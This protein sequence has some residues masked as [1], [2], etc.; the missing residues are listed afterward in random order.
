MSVKIKLSYNTD[1]ELA[2]VI[3]LLSPALKSYKMQPPKGRYNRAYM[4]LKPGF[5]VRSGNE[6]GK[7]SP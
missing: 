7:K 1:E 3:R 6:K 5:F 4:D 2:G